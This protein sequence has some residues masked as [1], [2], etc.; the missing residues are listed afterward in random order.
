MVI[1]NKTYFYILIHPQ[2]LSFGGLY[3]NSITVSSYRVLRTT[4]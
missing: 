2:T 4:Q 1:I 3:A